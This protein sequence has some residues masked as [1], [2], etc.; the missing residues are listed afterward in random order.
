M[1]LVVALPNVMS[2]DG[3]HHQSSG[4]RPTTSCTTNR[5]TARSAIIHNWWCDHARLVVP[6]PKLA[7][8]LVHN[9]KVLTMSAVCRSW[10][11]QTY[12]EEEQYGCVSSWHPIFYQVL[13]LWHGGYIL[14]PVDWTGETTE[15]TRG[16]EIVPEQCLNNKLFKVR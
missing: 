9:L 11:Y 6:S 15:D 10:R 12:T 1:S 8:K 3:W 4:G 14:C 16:R 2:Y 7:Q 13:K 5:A